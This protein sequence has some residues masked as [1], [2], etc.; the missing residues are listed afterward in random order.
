MKILLFMVGTIATILGIYFYINNKTPLDKA[1]A[2]LF[3]IVGSIAFGSATLLLAL[4]KV[5]A[6]KKNQNNKEGL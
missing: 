6:Q 2:G 4:N 3:L 5:D 1:I